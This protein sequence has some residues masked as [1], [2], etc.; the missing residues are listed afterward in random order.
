MKKDSPRVYVPPPMIYAA[1]FLLS[2]LLQR[3]MPAGDSFHGK[4]AASLTG[5][6][7]FIRETQ[8]LQAEGAAKILSR[9]IPTAEGESE[10]VI[11]RSLLRNES[12]EL[13]LGFIPVIKICSR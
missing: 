3:I 4:S 9:T 5:L 11:P 8:F 10:G 13:A 2:I 1:F 12:P 7:L 6:F